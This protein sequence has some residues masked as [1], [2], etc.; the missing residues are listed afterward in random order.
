MKIRLRQPQLI[1]EIGQRANQEDFIYPSQPKEGE[2]LFILCDG[3]GGHEKGEVASRVI[4]EE[5]ARYLGARLKDDDILSDDLFR[6]AFEYACQRLDQMDDGN[7]SMRKMGTTLTFL[8]FHKGG[9]LAAHVG[10]SRIYHI[11]PANRRMLYKSKDHS[12]VVELY[13][14]GEI[15]YSEMSS[16][17]QKN[18]ITRA[19]M[20]GKEKR[21][22]ADIV[23]ITD[24][25][26]G[27]YF[28]LCSDGM[29]ERMGDDELVDIISQN[30]TDEEKRQRL[31]T[32]SAPNRD[33][34]SAILLCVDDVMAEAGDDKYVGDEAVSPFN[35]LLMR[36]D[37]ED[38]DVTVTMPAPSGRKPVNVEDESTEI[39]PPVS[40]DK[41]RVPPSPKKSN[42]PS[43]ARVWGVTILWALVSA[44]LA[45]ALFYFI[46]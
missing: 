36:K 45:A 12:L 16:S 33:N 41:T 46:L 43:K 22:R 1:F 10:D 18:V 38:D 7:D 4:A 37:E 11:R 42:G 20:P 9:C 24:I 5:M 15:S 34:H 32:E 30:T 27:D 23:H 35:A 29:M 8:C 31:M 39:I 26:K 13:M 3:M 14:A 19:V 25:R 21:V 17:K 44:A 28:Y 2:R 40:T 6:M